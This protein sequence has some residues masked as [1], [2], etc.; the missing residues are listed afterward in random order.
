MKYPT[1]LTLAMKTIPP[2]IK[3]NPVINSV[4]GLPGRMEVGGDKYERM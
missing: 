3:Q 4:G 1:E 2:A